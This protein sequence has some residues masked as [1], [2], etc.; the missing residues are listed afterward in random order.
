LLRIRSRVDAV[1]ELTGCHGNRAGSS[2][3]V[4]R[5]RRGTGYGVSLDGSGNALIVEGNSIA[6]TEAI[7]DFLFSDD[8]LL[9]FLHKV[10]GPNGT[11]SN[12]EVLIESNSVNGSAG[13]FHILAYRTHP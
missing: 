10:T 2:Q 9:P 12:F 13:P 5:Y 8:A 1:A 3:D 4:A 7:S 6:G 11:L